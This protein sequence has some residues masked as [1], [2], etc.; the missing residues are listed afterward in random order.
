M[1]DKEL[2]VEVIARITEIIENY[3]DKYEL[4]LIFGYESPTLIQKLKRHIS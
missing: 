2:G 1:Q 3:D 4:E